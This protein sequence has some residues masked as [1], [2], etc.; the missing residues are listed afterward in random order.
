M[1]S[2][3]ASQQSSASFNRRIVLDL[4]RRSG[5]ISRKDLVSQ[6]ALSPQTV[7][8]ITR[9]L[10]SSDILVSRRRKA[11]KSRGQPPIVFALNPHGGMSIGISL[12]PG[13]V[14]AALV[15]LTGELLESE[16]LELDS[17]NPE[18]CLEAM[19]SMV[20]RLKSKA[21][22]DARVWGIGVSLPG[23]FGAGELSFVGPTAFDGWQ[24]LRVL[25]Q[26]HDKTGLHVS[27]STDSKAG[28]LGESLYG[29]AKNLKNFFYVHIG[30]GLGGV[31]VNGASVYQGAD[32]NATELGH[33][34]IAPGG[35]QCNCG[36]RGCLERYVSI[37]AFSEHYKRRGMEPPGMEQVGNLI[38]QDDEIL[39]EWLEEASVHLRHAICFIENTLDPETIVIGG[40]AP[41]VLVE[42]L[43]EGTHPQMHSVRG[44]RGRETARV[45]PAQHQ[46]E[47][48]ILGAA[49]LPIHD[50][51]APRLESPQRE[52]Q[53][54]HRAENILGYR[55]RP[56]VGKL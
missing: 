30:Y 33:V 32:G 18:V 23:P 35:R 49:V 21:G 42:R 51:I 34:P 41:R 17:N 24:D 11:K 5:E 13:L 25:E 15:N 45:I 53:P 50:M 37:L 26:L 47:S 4:V 3:G 9:E 1:I 8:N 39:V 29:A 44:G 38:L 43:I 12:E 14:S 27:F 54:D 20:S 28:A 40:G 36:N 52:Q 56:A 10:E 6:V 2:R 16:R 48:A 46:A 31:L 55:P 22:A 7:A 19:L